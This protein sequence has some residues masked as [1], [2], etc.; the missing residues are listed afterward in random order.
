MTISLKTKDDTAWAAELAVQKKNNRRRNQAQGLKKNKKWLAM[1][2][3][4]KDDV[5]KALALQA[6][7][8]EED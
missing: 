8:I 4:D 3:A 7:F 2:D 5:L 1:N 6:G